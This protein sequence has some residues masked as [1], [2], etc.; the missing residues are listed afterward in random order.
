MPR[1]SARSSSLPQG[2]TS[3]KVAQY[4]QEAT[5]LLC[6]RST[7]ID[8]QVS[9]A[10]WPRGACRRTKGAAQGRAGRRG[11]AGGSTAAGPGAPGQAR[12]PAGWPA[13]HPAAGTRPPGAGSSTR[14]GAPAR[15]ALQV[16]GCQTRARRNPAPGAPACYEGKWAAIRCPGSLLHDWHALPMLALPKLW[17]AAA[18]CQLSQQPSSGQSGRAHAWGWRRL[19]VRLTARLAPAACTRAARRH[20]GH[21]L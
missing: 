3:A 13:Q 19:Q 8:S 5:H 11:P 7:G 18:F 6:S 12:P 17:L 21:P 16:Q 14:P 2:A 4:V 1:Q 9:G 15:P 20:P 10:Q